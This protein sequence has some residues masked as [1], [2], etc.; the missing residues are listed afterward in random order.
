MKYV[1][2]HV[3]EVCSSGVVSISFSE[4]S[5]VSGVIPIDLFAVQ[6]NGTGVVLSTTSDVFSFSSVHHQLSYVH[7][8]VSLRDVCFLAG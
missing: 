3:N 8:E 1:D 2:S 7:S 5:V 6:V 4:Q